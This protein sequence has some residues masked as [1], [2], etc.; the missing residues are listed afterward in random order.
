MFVRFK[1]VNVVRAILSQRISLRGATLAMALLLPMSVAYAQTMIA[2]EEE[3]K[4]L[5]KVDDTLQA[6]SE[7]PFGE[8]ISLYDG[9]LSFE[10][11]DVSVPGT[12]PTITVGRQYT[13][14]TVEDRPG[15]KNLAFGDW[16]I[17]LPEIE[18]TTAAQSDVTGWL[19]NT[20]PRTDI[21]SGFR[22]PPTVA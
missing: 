22:E 7:N 4:K 16:D 2:P 14:P 5:I 15:L 18:T 21:C 20:A 19:V 1:R 6:L 10:Q 11:G 8:R 12:G 3:Y 13:L 9:S 17:S